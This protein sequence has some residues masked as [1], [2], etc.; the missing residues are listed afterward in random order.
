MAGILALTVALAVYAAFASVPFGLVIAIVGVAMAIRAG[1]AEERAR[2][3]APDPV[4]D[5]SPD[6]ANEAVAN[7]PPEP[8]DGVTAP[9]PPRIEPIAVMS[10]ILAMAG[11]SIAGAA[12]V[13][14][15]GLALIS[16]G[17]VTGYRS[18]SRRL[19]LVG[20]IAAM[21]PI[22]AMALPDI[23]HGTSGEGFGA[24]I[25]LGAIAAAPFVGGWIGGRSW[26]SLWP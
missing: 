5:T 4:D 6:P 24:V 14:V 7:D 20:A 26:R 23:R 11:V 2:A 17:A 8:S 18:S 15:A 13:P 9:E 12:G 1:A 3:A 16:L 25:V 21:L 19:L 22:L 10:A